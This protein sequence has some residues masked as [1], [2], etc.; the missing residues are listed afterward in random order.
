MGQI[1]EM[2]DNAINPFDSH[3][4]KALRNDGKTGVMSI[5]DFQKALKNDPRWATTKNA[6]EEAS[7]YANSILRSFGLLA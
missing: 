1:L 7:G 4:Q 6:R 3:I 5:T 2:P